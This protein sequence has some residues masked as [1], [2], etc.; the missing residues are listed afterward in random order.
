MNPNSND[1]VPNPN[2]DRNEN[3]P[4]PPPAA[5]PPQTAANNPYVY[6]A[7][8]QDPP[9]KNTMETVKVMFGRWAKKAAEATKKGQ[10]YA[11]DMWQHLKMGPS[12]TDAAVGRIAQGTKV[13][14]EGGYEKIFRTTFQTIP[15]ERFLKSYACYLSTSAGPVMGVLYV[16]TAKLAFCSDNPLPYRV[17]DEKKWSYYK[18]LIPLLQLKAIQPS[19]SKTNPAEKY[20]QVI[21]VDDHE[22]WFMGFVYYDSAVKHLQGAL[23]PHEYPNC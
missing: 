14:A 23:Q 1:N 20:I 15:E 16:S 6:A 7:P 9:R 11:G 3:I 2:V 18:V 19:K 22:F 5:G 4:P 8:V 13:L 21:S 12:I 17:G 10:E